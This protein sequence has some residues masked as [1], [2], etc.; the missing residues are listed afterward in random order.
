VI[1]VVP[2][3]GTGKGADAKRPLH[4]PERLSAD[5]IIAFSCE[6][7]DNGQL[8]ICEFVARDRKA[9]VPILS[10]S[11][12]SGRV[13]EKGKSRR[14]DIERELKKHKK[15]FNIARFGANAQ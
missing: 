11:R 13:F 15:D 8:A 7:S 2:M 14:D 10:D 1:A 5:R 4:A 3:N 12:L 6:M 9:L